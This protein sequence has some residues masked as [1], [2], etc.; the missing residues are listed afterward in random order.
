MMLKYCNETNE[1]FTNRNFF[2]G[3]SHTT[4]IRELS[5]SVSQVRQNLF[6]SKILLMKKQRYTRMSCSTSSTR[7]TWDYSLLVTVYWLVQWLLVSC[8]NKLGVKCPKWSRWK[9]VGERKREKNHLPPKKWRRI[10]LWMYLRTNIHS[11]TKSVA[12]YYIDYR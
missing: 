8:I 1:R 6:S 11:T 12:H 5:H 9:K 2:F 3:L 10:G 7:F 4:K